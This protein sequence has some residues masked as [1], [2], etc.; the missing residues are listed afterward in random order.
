MVSFTPYWKRPDLP[1]LLGVLALLWSFNSAGQGIHV[2]SAELVANAGEYYLSANF[3][4]E[5]NSTLEEALVRGVALHFVVQFEVIY[6]RWYTLYLWNR[7]IVAHEQR[8]RLA[9]NALTRQYRLSI[10]SLHQSFDTLEE[11]LALLGRFSR[12]RV[13]D[14]DALVSG[15]VYEAQIRMALDTKQ[16]PK[17]FQIDA[18]A[19]RDWSL[20][21]EWYRWTLTP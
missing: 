17:P 1:R 5:L 6:P 21:S 8:Y 15:R 2:K 14:T 20:A 7:R 18:L 19:S 16:L 3:E 13:L 10:D 11:A 12:R 4:V 9:Y